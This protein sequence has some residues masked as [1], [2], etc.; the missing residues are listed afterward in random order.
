MD[1]QDKWQW[2]DRAV[3]VTKYNPRLFDGN[4]VYIKD[5]WTSY[6]DIGKM[7]G[8]HRFTREEYER[9]EMLY[10]EAVGLFMHFIG[11]NQVQI[12]D[13]NRRYAFL[14]DCKKRDP[15]LYDTCKGLKD[16]SVIK[17]VQLQQVLQLV[18][19][20]YIQMSLLVEKDSNSHILLGY[21]YYMYFVSDKEVSVLS[22]AVEKVGL[23]FQVSLA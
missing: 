2:L 9:V 11:V 22:T 10:I 5:E 1:T 18:L 20:E 3:S 15:Q 13:Y 21:D 16:G 8:G 12:N 23:F 19:R 7:Y 14:S 4:N 17:G 6:S